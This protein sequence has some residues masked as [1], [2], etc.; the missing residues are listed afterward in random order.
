MHDDITGTTTHL[1]LGNNVSLSFFATSCQQLPSTHLYIPIASSLNAPQSRTISILTM[2][3]SFFL[4]LIN[5]PILYSSIPLLGLSL[6]LALHHP[7]SPFRIS[8]SPQSL[9]HCQFNQPH[10]SPVGDQSWSF[11]SETLRNPGF[12]RISPATAKQISLGSVL[13]LGLG[14]TLRIFSKALV[15]AVGLGVIVVQVGPHT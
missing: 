11:P 3:S 12:G 5:R 6:P 9:I 8:Q 4:P 13:G 2:A 14:I 7:S 10:S 1:F 15:L